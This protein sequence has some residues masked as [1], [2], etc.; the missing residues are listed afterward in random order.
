[1]NDMSDMSRIC[2]MVVITK[3]R[4]VVEEADQ[5]RYVTVQFG[6]DTKEGIGLV[7]QIKVSVS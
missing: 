5:G 2:K 1:M 3:I 4:L 7:D 6:S